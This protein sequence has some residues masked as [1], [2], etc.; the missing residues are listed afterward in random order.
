MFLIYLILSIFYSF[1]FS[2]NP[3]SKLSTYLGPYFKYLFN[4]IKLLYYFYN[5][6]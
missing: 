6:L 3:L 1:N 4:F 5:Y 2:T